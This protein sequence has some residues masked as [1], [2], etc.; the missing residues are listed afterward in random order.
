ML[1][2][3]PTGSNSRA[4]TVWPVLG[5]E[6]MSLKRNI[7]AMLS[8]VLLAGSFAWADVESGPESERSYVSTQWPTWVEAFGPASEAASLDA[9]PSRFP[10]LPH[11]VIPELPPPYDSESALWS[12]ATA[13]R[14]GGGLAFKPQPCSLL[15]LAT[16]AVYLVRMGT[17]LT[18]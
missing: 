1:K 15:L 5:C 16:G 2:A 11:A 7:A 3:G 4:A 14:A 18:R 13:R 9:S 8:C 10:L 6:K 17:R 12:F